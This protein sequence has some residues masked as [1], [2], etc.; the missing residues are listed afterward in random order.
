[1][2][3]PGTAASKAALI[4]MNSAMGTTK[5]SQNSTNNNITVSS[6]PPSFDSSSSSSSTTPMTTTTMME[7]PHHVSNDAAVKEAEALNRVAVRAG[8]SGGAKDYSKGLAQV[9]NDG[10]IVKAVKRLNNGV[11]IE[12]IK[13]SFLREILDFARCRRIPSPP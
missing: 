1:M 11:D 7:G 6:G 8:G 2:S 9:F 5:M 10:Q 4:A 3:T 12:L 13:D